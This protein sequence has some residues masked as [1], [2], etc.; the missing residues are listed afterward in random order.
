MEA[1]HG[2]PVALCATPEEAVRAAD[3]VCTTSLAKAPIVAGAWLRPGTH[4]NAVGAHTLDAREVDSDTIARARVY[5]DALD[6]V[7]QESGDIMLP[8]QEGRITLDHV[9][10]EIGEVI[11][12]SKP[13]RQ[14]RD[15]VTFYKSHG[16]GIQ[17]VATAHMV[18]QKALRLGRGTWLDI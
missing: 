10:G 9:V 15:E 5:V 8:V 6:A 2:L 1:R 16:I 17:D 14:T 3:I 11:A 7:P 18:Y 12:G 4:I 13:G